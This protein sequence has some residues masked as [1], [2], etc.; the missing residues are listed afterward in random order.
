MKV[1]DIDHIT[2]FVDDLEKCMRFYH[3]VF[4]LP[5]LKFDDKQLEFQLGKQKLIFLPIISD[6]KNN[7]KNPTAGSGK[8]CIITKD[9]LSD[10]TSHLANYGVDI[11]DG[12]KKVRGAN[13]EMNSIYVNDP[14][15]NIIEICEYKD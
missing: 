15:N 7:P 1:K 8:F 11:I 4:D 12:P 10:I 3:E 2:I 6:E 5:I 9:S 14:E 13:G